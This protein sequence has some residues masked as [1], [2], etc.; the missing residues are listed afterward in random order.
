MKKFSL[1]AV[2]FLT[3]VSS[4]FGAKIYPLDRAE[5]VADSKFDIKV[6]FN[7]ELNLEDAKVE[8]NGKSLKDTFGDKIEFIQ[9][10]EGLGSTIWVRDITLPK[11]NYEVV[12]SGDDKDEV[13]KWEMFESKKPLAKNV[14]F[15]VGDGL[16]VAHRTAAR[17]MIGGSTE[18]K[19][20]KNLAMDDMTYAAFLGIGAQDSIG[21]DSANTMSAFMTGQKSAVNSMGSFT[22]RSSNPFNHPKFINI[23]EL[24]KLHSNKSLG[25]VTDAEVEDATP[26]A[27]VAHTRARA[28]K[29]EIVDQI[30][31]LKPDVVLGGGSAYFLPQSTPGSKR[32][33]DKNYIDEFKNAGYSLATNATELSKIDIKNTDKL[34]G[35]FHTGNLNTIVDIKFLKEN[36]VTKNFPDQPELPDMAKTALDIL[37]KNKDGF[38]L[39]VE[40]AHI[41]KAS[42]PLD[43]ERAVMCTIMLD[44]VVK[45]ALDF[46]KENPDTLIVV[47]G[48]H[49]HPIS[50]IGTID[51]NKPGDKMREK[52]GIYQHAGFPTYEDKDN[53]GYPDRL[54]VDVRLAVFFAAFPDY[55]E[56]FRPKLDKQFVPT[57]KNEKGKYIANEEY[58]NVKG[59]VFREGNLPTFEGT[60][61]HA[62]DDMI[63]LG[64]GPGANKFK[65]YMENTEVFR[66]LVETLGIKPKKD[67]LKVKFHEDFI[68]S[69]HFVLAASYTKFCQ[70]SCGTKLWRTL[71]KLGSF[72]AWNV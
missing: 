1:A 52:V 12:A 57:I 59:A 61:I 6:E 27:V 18:G 53:D 68:K 70:K 44:K 28:K 50:V 64:E 43:W 35:L 54:D 22:S 32:K 20:N 47:V 4:V 19:V 51:D 45:M 23:G 25:I 55:Y 71:F 42:H 21:T 66:V 9:N 26:A 13:V 48:D 5:L 31:A 7:K 72:R 14:I 67:W 36:G 63:V 58:K 41:D 69:S 11:G 29:A 65:G 56:T 60:G 49:T 17:L 24:I 16:S 34:L 37:S 15:I 30:F 40:S 38:F 2:L 3:S 10:E 46:Q 62:V 33:D 39:M 8:I